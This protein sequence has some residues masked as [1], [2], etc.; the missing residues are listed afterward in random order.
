MLSKTCSY[1][2]DSKALRCVWFLVLNLSKGYAVCITSPYRAWLLLLLLMGVLSCSLSLC[3]LSWVNSSSNKT[4][5]D[6]FWLLSK[7]PFEYSLSAFLM[8]SEC[9]LNLFTP[10]GPHINHLFFDFLQLIENK[11]TFF[12]FLFLLDDESGL[13][14]SKNKNMDSKCAF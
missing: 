13:F 8:L 11:K 9:S 3:S 2:D 1:N 7:V 4:K 6:K 12:C 10:V 5:Y 14:W